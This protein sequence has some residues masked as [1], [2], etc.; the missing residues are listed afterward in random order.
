MAAR[1]R[2]RVATVAVSDIFNH[3][4]WMLAI[5]LHVSAELNLLGGWLET[6]QVN[7]EGF[8]VRTLPSLQEHPQ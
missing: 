4:M 5:Q 1:I 2:T 8:H 7:H 6:N 3:Y